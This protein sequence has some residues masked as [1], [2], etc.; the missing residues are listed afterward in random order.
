MN[1]RK[2]GYKK[3]YIPLTY[4]VIISIFNLLTLPIKILLKKLLVRLKNS[5]QNLKNVL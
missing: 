5:G 4:K 3:E 2:T 1:Y